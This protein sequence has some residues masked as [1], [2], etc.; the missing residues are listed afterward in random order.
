MIITLFNWNNVLN[1]VIS[2]L[3]KKGYTITD[4]VKKGELL[5]I[6]NEAGL[7]A[8]DKVKE[9][10][11]LGKKVILI[12]HGRR[13]TSRIFPPFNEKMISD[14]TCVWGKGDKERLISAGIPEDKIVIT[15][16]SIFRHLKPKKKHKQKNIVFSPEHWC[17]REVDENLCVAST[18][19]R[20]K[21]KDIKI[22]TKVLE[23][24]HN[25]SWYDN[26]IGS[27][28]C[29]DNHLEI[30][31]EVLSKADI[32]VGLTE[33]TFELMAQIMDIPVIVSDIWM[34]KDCNRDKRYLKYR[35]E[36]SNA[37]VIEKDISKLNNTVLNY[38]ENPSKLKKER[39]LIGIK[40]GGIN[41]KNP[42]NNIIKVIEKYA[43]NT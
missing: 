4:D 15:G 31:A 30:C 36:F 32:V 5:I 1:D 21:T 6:W 8:R 39:S 13:G 3:V 41:I 29:G 34:P 17:G 40:D 27:D 11:A 9:A 22:I 33:G 24:E 19:S 10:K 23:K 12:Q 18:L 26:P 28:R 16:T 38:L 35:R 43:K 2:G 37:C 42:V 14:I 20:L 25:F 7:G